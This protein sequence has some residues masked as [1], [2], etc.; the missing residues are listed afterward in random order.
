MRPTRVRELGR[1]CPLF[2]ILASVAVA[3]DA[4]PAEELNWR[5]T[6]SVSLIDDSTTV[7]V[8]TE[9]QDEISAWPDKKLRPSLVIRHSR[10]R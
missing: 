6:T 10:Q 1:F 3:Q 7:T 5:V 9:A 8:S 4:P 2:L